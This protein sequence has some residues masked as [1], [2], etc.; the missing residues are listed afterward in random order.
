GN[1]MVA[2]GVIE[3]TMIVISGAAGMMIGWSILKPG[4]LSRRDAITQAS[5]K[6]VRL[7][8]GVASFL[9]IAGII[10]GFVSPSALPAWVKWLVGGVT[11][12]MMVA[13]FGWLGR[14]SSSFYPDNP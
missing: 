5:G 7:M 8:V 12:L 10:E 3:L 6:A 11:G 13:Y 4:F 9:V 1:F 14:E 2:H